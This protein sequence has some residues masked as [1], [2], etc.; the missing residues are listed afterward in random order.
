M[1]P[2]RLV[3]LQDYGVKVMEDKRQNP[4]EVADY[5]W[6]NRKVKPGTVS[7]IEEGQRGD[8]KGKEWV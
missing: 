8:G 3:V 7:T 2:I 1:K 6:K 4:L 5:V